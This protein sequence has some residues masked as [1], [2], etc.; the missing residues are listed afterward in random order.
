MSPSAEYWKAIEQLLS[1]VQSLLRADCVALYPMEYAPEW[2]DEVTT[3]IWDRVVRTGLLDRTPARLSQLREIKEQ[4]CGLY[5]VKV[6]ELEP[7]PCNPFDPEFD[8]A[9][10][11]RDLQVLECKLREMLECK[12]AGTSD[13]TTP[14]AASPQEV[15]M[16]RRSRPRPPYSEHD[17]HV[18]ECIGRDD[19]QRLSVAALCKQYRTTWNE[20]RPG[21]SQDAFRASL[22]RIRNYLKWLSLQR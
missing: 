15:Q 6:I 18:C 4:I 8:H 16:T 13:D 12:D 9:T 20:L 14:R 1:E 10:I 11:A 22:Y 19:V 17:K 21:A 7:P 2:E 5:L 3:L